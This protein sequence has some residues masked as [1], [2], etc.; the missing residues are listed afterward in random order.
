MAAPKLVWKIVALF[1]LVGS[2]LVV[3]ASAS[4]EQGTVV[5]LTLVDG[6]ACRGPIV[7]TT[8]SLVNAGANYACTDGRWIMGEPLSLADGRQTAMLARTALQGQPMGDG[9]PCTDSQ[10]PT[11]LEQVEVATAATLPR[12]VSYSPNTMTGSAVTCTFQDGNTFYLGGVRA[13]YRCDPA[14]YQ[15]RERAGAYYY[16]GNDAEWWILGGLYD[17][18]MGG[19]LQGSVVMIKRR[20]VQVGTGGNNRSSYP[21][22]CN[23]EVCVLNTYQITFGRVGSA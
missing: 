17:T 4:A 8:F 6:T 22:L 20:G 14:F 9:A 16:T 13:N 10:C 18:G 7:G 11:A 3:P 1:V 12:I 15:D 19:A 21:I 23:N 5:L 2:T